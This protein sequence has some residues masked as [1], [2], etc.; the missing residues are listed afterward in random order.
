MGGFFGLGGA[1]F[2]G[3]LNL[4]SKNCPVSWGFFGGGR[5]DPAAA[6]PMLAIRRFTSASPFLKSRLLAARWRGGG[7]RIIFGSDPGTSCMGT[8][9]CCDILAWAVMGA[10][11][12]RDVLSACSRAARAG[13]SRFNAARCAREA[14]I[15]S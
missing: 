9:P 7:F 11:A 13:S 5:L 15:P 2:I 6:S 4:R 3:V 12:M 1:F 10:A 8:S 14:A